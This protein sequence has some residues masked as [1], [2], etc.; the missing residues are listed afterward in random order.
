MQPKVSV[1][2]P[3]YNYARY[4]P[5]AVD[6][7]FEQDVELIIVNDGSSDETESVAKAIV[8]DWLCAEKK[9]NFINLKENIGM[10]MARNEGLVAST[11]EFILFLDADDMRISGS[12][13]KQLD[14]F[15][16]HPEVMV[17]W[18][19][20][21]ELRGEY[22][23]SEAEQQK[24]KLHWHSAEVN[25]QTVLYRREVFEKYGG[26]YE[27]LR[28]GTDKEM[29]M[30][31]GLH[32]DSPF[33]GRLKSK[34]LKIPLAYYRK[35]PDQTHKLRKADPIWQHETKHIQKDRLKQVQREGITRQN[36]RFPI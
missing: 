12:I 25:P 19:W 33:H 15:G 14:Y 24:H 32:P 28:S 16:D 36:T 8:Y 17:T 27:G 18:G 10:P 21:L 11:G 9:V 4:L 3:C 6:S 35:H 26:F 7:V 31:L 23:F 1:I 5:H 30:R 13:Q 34:K 20:A 22:S 2:I 29:C